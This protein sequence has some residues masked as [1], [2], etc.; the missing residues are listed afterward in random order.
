M[1][2]RI[3]TGVLLAGTLA[4][5]DNQPLQIVDTLG[6]E[7]IDALAE[8]LLDQTLQG[9]DQ[10]TDPQGA[11][12]GDGPAGAPV[13]IDTSIEFQASCS[14]GGLVDLAA[15]LTGTVD[16]D[17]GTGSLDLSVVQ[18]HQ[19]CRAVHAES[20]KE[21]LLDGAPSLTADYAVSW[22]AG[23]F[24]AVGSYGGAIDWTVEGRS[25]RC[26]VAVAFDA[27]GMLQQGAT[28]ASLT[29]TICG[30]AFSHT[31]SR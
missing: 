26:D 15:D 12:A 10:I 1:R 6:V 7:E 4:A 27:E 17:A 24:D 16:A 14:L 28:S 21:F 9:N 5:C 29:G 22:S 3:L 19:T 13:Q 20:G 18:T 8:V 25:G 23:A 30:R 11:V 2:A 31:V